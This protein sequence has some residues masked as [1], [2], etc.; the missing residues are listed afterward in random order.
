MNNTNRRLVYRGNNKRNSASNRD[1]NRGNVKGKNT[2]NLIYVMIALF[3]AAYVPSIYNLVCGKC[4]NVGFISMG[5]IEES[6]NVNGY[7]IRDETLINAPLTGKYVSDVQ[8]GEKVQ[9][10]QMI[11]KV[12][13]EGDEDILEDIKKLDF[14][15]LEAKRSKANNKEVYNSDISKIDDKIEENINLLIKETNDSKYTGYKRVKSDI[16]AL[17][18]KKSE[19]IGHDAVTDSY[20]DTKI[21]ERNMLYAKLNRQDKDIKADNTGVISFCVDGLEN[22]LKISSIQELDYKFFD[23]NEIKNVRRDSDNL[24]VTANTPFAKIINGIDA[25][26][27]SVMDEGIAVRYKEGELVKVRFNDI[28]KL[29]TGS[30]VRKNNS[31]GKSVVVVKISS[32]L[33]YLSSYRVCNIDLISNSYS[34][35]KVLRKSLKDYD[36]DS[37]TARIGVIKSNKVEY[38]DVNVL[39]YNK[40]FAIIENDPLEM[41]S[42]VNLYDEFVIE[43]ENVVEGQI[44]NKV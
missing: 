43:P 18:M 39:G 34:G 28:N 20:I 5:D 13:L 16:D 7:I 35:Y 36:K 29:V 19:I 21:N 14:E 4:I 30:V 17:M 27:A 38:R 22:I 26:V 25:Y 33:Q 12:L 15:I 23:S 10:N 40:E 41:D 37:G 1:V 11:A 24:V 44:I 3:L 6:I 32:A 31:K 8:E 42:R 2:S 9:A